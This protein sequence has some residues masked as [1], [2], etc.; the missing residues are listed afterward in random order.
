MPAESFLPK[1]DL[2]ILVNM[3]TSWDFVL[4]AQMAKQNHKD[5]KKKGLFQKSMLASFQIKSSNGNEDRSSLAMV[6][7]RI[8]V[9]KRA[10]LTRIREKRQRLIRLHGH[11]IT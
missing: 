10:L 6:L 8:A 1:R 3:V 2:A 11:R 7:G 5:V 9:A 4:M